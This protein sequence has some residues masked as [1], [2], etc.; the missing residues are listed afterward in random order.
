MSSRLP[1]SALPLS[2][3]ISTTATSPSKRLTP[4]RQSASSMSLLPSPFLASTTPRGAAAATGPLATL[5]ERGV[6][7]TSRSRTPSS[8][9]IDQDEQQEQLEGDESASATPP[10]R[11]LDL[12]VQSAEKDKGSPSRHS[13]RVSLVRKPDPVEDAA[14]VWDFYFDDSNETVIS[15]ALSPSTEPATPAATSAVDRPQEDD[16]EEDPAAT[17]PFK[18]NVGPPPRRFRSSTST[19]LLSLPTETVSAPSSLS[20]SVNPSPT[21][22]PPPPPLALPLPPPSTSTRS[23]DAPKTPEYVPQSPTYPTS[24]PPLNTNSEVESGSLNGFSEG[25]IGSFGNTSADPL[26]GLGLGMASYF[27]ATESTRGKKRVSEEGLEAN[28][29]KRAKLAPEIESNAH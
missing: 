16:E 10:R 4:L 24:D 18:E 13:D 8:R 19:S 17:A 3:F 7:S 15:P 2:Q 20:G 23:F 5:Y 26:D 22:T 27:G 21:H 14:P 28:H 12:F 9:L 25:A 1:L 11:L 6:A 29:D